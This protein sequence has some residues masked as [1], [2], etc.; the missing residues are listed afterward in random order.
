MTEQTRKRAS[1]SHQEGKA[2]RKKRELEATRA[3]RAE[4]REALSSTEAERQA[5]LQLCFSVCV[6]VNHQ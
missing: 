3:L 5:L 1:Q 6:S 2:D 4:Y